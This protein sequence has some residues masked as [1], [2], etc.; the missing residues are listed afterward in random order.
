M[1]AFHIEK[2]IGCCCYVYVLAAQVDIWST[3][4]PKSLSCYYH[5]IYIYIYLIHIIY[6]YLIHIIYICLIHIIYV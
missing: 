5:Y 1:P 3:L 2:H 4:L 6:I